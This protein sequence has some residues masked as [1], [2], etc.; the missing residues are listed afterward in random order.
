MNKNIQRTFI[1]GD[2]WLYY[3]IYCGTKTADL[4]LTEVIKPITEKL[5]TN[6]IIDKWFF[7]RYS[8]PKLHLRVRFHYIEPKNIFDIIK[9]VNSL[10]KTYIEQNLI[11][12]VQID[13]YQ[14]EIERYGVNTM[15][16][17]ENLFFHDSNMIV[18]MIE[19]ID[20]DEGEIIRW[21]FGLRAINSL[22][23]DFQYELQQKLELLKI[24]KENFGKE[25]GMN[26]FLK[27]QLD[28]KY[29]KEQPAINDVLDRTKDETSEMLLL[30]KLL[31]QKS[32]IT[33]P[34][35]KEILILK[36]NN[37][38]NPTLNNLMSSYIHMMMNRLF[39]SKQRMHEMV[40]YDFLY[41]YYNSEIA[42]KNS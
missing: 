19:L 2:E 4:I 36:Q 27:K 8:D 25:F 18:N 22:L 9:S 14:R 6:N 33:L 41:R 17:A 12:K 29:R 40:L 24:L 13:T 16:L 3:K 20:G 39:K 1:I 5:L 34:V 38:L 21:L 32:I 26:R 10:S 23:D 42:K 35:I 11:W 31:N 15:E 7:I 37:Q 28:E 30:L